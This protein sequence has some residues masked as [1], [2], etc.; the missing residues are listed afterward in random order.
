MLGEFSLNFFLKA[1]ESDEDAYG[2]DTETLE[3]PITKLTLYNANV[4][5]KIGDFDSLENPFIIPF[6][7][8]CHS[9][10]GN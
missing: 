6:L 10:N 3:K 4:N 1:S 5:C 9:D 8:N 2:D 7:F